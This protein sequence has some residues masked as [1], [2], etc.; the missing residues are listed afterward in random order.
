MADNPLLAAA[1]RF[2]GHIGPFL[3]V[4]LRM[5]LLANEAM[6]RAPLETRAVVKLEPRPPRS[7]AVDGIQYVTGCT[8]GKGNI[9][10]EPDP[11]LIWARFTRGLKCL[12]IS[13][14]EGYLR[15]IETDL[16]NASEKAIID[17]AFKM[18]D[19]PPEE[20]FEVSR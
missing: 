11:G 1:G 4:G 16:E 2:H 8:M 3:A 14:T 7:C 18:M 5:G 6:G 19:T 20:M 12:T 13:L 17:Y 10:I 9:E 15:R